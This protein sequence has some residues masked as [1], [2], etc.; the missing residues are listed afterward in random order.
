MIATLIFVGLHMLEFGTFIPQIWK[1]IKTKSSK[2]I[3]IPA[4]IIYV[5]MNL[6]WMVYWIITKV[7]WVQMLASCT[8]MT[9][10]LIQFILVLMYHK[11]KKEA[12][13]G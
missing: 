13:D 1:L 10:V 5:I 8:V 3:S 2:D 9:E 4:Q 6:C 7:N 12:L 11:P